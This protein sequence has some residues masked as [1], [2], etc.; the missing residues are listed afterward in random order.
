MQA[1]FDERG[2]GFFHRRSAGCQHGL[3]KDFGLGPLATVF[4]YLGEA[5]FCPGIGERLAGKVLHDLTK[6]HSGTVEGLFFGGGDTGNFGGIAQIDEGE[7]KIADFYISLSLYG[8]NRKFRNHMLLQI[9][10]RLILIQLGPGLALGIERIGLVDFI[11]LN[12]QNG[13]GDDQKQKHPV[14]AKENV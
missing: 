8:R 1:I 13:Q 14:L 4:I 9:L 11:K 2:E 6:S 3:I 5:Q 10:R 7:V 12:R